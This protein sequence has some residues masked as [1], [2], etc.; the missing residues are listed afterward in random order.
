MNERKHILEFSVY[1]TK[2][3]NLIPMET[4]GTFNTEI[5]TRF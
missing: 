4:L 5:E 1:K 3:D 2:E